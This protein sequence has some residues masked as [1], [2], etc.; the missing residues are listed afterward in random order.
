MNRRITM[1]MPQRTIVAGGGEELGI[2]HGSLPRFDHLYHYLSTESAAGTG[3]Q[4]QCQRE[5]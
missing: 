3:L 1:H 2:S 4:A 5:L